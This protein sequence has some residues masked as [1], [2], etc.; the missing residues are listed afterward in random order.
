MARREQLEAL[1][2]VLALAARKARELSHDGSNAKL[3][4]TAVQLDKIV[5]K[6][7]SSAQSVGNGRSHDG[8]GQ[9][10]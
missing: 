5:R 3:A 9:D 10:A 6:L 7:R 4:N 8:R 2:D 1:A